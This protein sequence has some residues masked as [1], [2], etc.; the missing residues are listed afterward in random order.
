MI[1][2]IGIDIPRGWAVVDVVPNGQ[3]IGVAIGELD[4][5]R[6]VEHFADLAC[7]HRVRLAAI[8]APLEPYMFGRGSSGNG[9]GVRRG[10]IVSLMKCARLAGRMEQ[11]SMELGVRSSVCTAAPIVVDA[12]QV[13]KALGIRGCTRTEKDQAVKQ[14][15]MMHV[16]GLPAKSNADERDAACVAI[17]GGLTRRT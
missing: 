17:Y 6:E 10:V 14:Y 3:S 8:E 9:E 13:R 4:E 12:D 16:R 15:V 2:V 1:R 5:G 7:S 11:K